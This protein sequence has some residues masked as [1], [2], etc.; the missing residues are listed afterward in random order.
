MSKIKILWPVVGILALIIVV[1][2]THFYK[3]SKPIPAP[4]QPIDE[5]ADWK[6]YTNEQYGFEFKYPS[7]WQF[8]NSLNKS[9]DTAKSKCVFGLL[10]KPAS[11]QNKGDLDF[12]DGVSMRFFITTGL[13]KEIQEYVQ[14]PKGYPGGK[15]FS[16]YEFT[17]TSET[18]SDYQVSAFKILPNSSVIIFDWD[19]VGIS[20]ED[21]SFDKYLNQ[22][23]STF[24]FTKK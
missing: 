20:V 14:Y 1:S 21:L 8:E 16:S 5:T 19:R 6:T 15:D 12:H 11:N 18:E 7:D 23:L 24:K 4:N 22:I 10:N 2:F 13:T 3:I 9:C 17:G